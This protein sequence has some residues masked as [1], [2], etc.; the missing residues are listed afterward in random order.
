MVILSIGVAQDA[1]AQITNLND[2]GYLSTCSRGLKKR[3]TADFEFDHVFAF[4]GFLISFTYIVISYNNVAM[5]VSNHNDE[6][7]RSV[8]IPIHMII[9]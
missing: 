6:F 9:K 4:V 8:K 1:F 2:G 5:R 7:Q 3:P